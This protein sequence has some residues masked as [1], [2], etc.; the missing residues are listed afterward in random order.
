MILMK[1]TDRSFLST[2]FKQMFILIFLYSHTVCTVYSVLAS[3]LSVVFPF[4]FFYEPE[5][6]S[7]QKEK[8]EVSVFLV[9]HKQAATRKRE[10]PSNPCEEANFIFSI[11]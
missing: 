2:L 6:L 7:Q 10:G 3:L 8:K 11:K 9:L 4:G 5:A 1:E